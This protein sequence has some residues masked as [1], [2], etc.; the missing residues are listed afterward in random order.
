VPDARYTSPRSSTRI[1]WHHSIEDEN[2]LISRTLSRTPD[3]EY[4]F[5]TLLAPPTHRSPVSG[6][7]AH[8]VALLSFSR[9]FDD[10]SMSPS[11]PFWTKSGFVTSV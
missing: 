10:H 1:F 7:I 6:W 3:D 4:R 2:P 9:I 11:P 8:V 5:T